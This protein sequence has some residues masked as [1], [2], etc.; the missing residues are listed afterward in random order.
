MTVSPLSR[1]NC[2]YG[3]SRFANC[4]VIRN[5]HNSRHDGRTAFGVRVEER[6]KQ[7]MPNWTLVE[8]RLSDGLPM[9]LY[10]GE[11]D[12]QICWASVWDDEHPRT[13]AEFLKQCGFRSQE[14]RNQ[15]SAVLE[16]AGRQ[17]EEYFAGIRQNFD[18]PLA[19]NGTR[20]Q[21]GVWRQLCAIP[22]GTTTTYGQLAARV[23]AP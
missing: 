7:S 15:H 1:V 18:L 17:V 12:A 23:D 13:E 19:L 6:P 11:R 2:S 21:V 20:F 10:I 3:I 16:Q 8:G 22:Y 5:R 14:E 9:R 4:I